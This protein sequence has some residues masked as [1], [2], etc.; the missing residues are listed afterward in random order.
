MDNTLIKELKAEA[1]SDA[2]TNFFHRRKK[3]FYR[4]SVAAIFFLLCFFVFSIIRN[5]LEEKYSK[6]LH[7]SLISEELGEFE[8]AK[9]NLAQIYNATFAP[10]GPKSLASMR[11]AGLLL[12][13]GKKDEALKIYQEIAFSSSYDDFIQELSGILAAKILVNQIN[14]TSDQ[15]LQN[16]TLA[17]LNKIVKNNK[18]L[19]PYTLEQLAIFYIKTQKNIEA[20][21]ALEEIIKTPNIAQSLAIRASDLI[22]LIS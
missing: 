3:I 1:R 4:I 6:I 18:I 2:I 10:S 13:E 9:E 16:K 14:K 11:Y 19:R 21:K 12:V 7:Q 20:R 5:N 17:E 8:K 15:E 22:K